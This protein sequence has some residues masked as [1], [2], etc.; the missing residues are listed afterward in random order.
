[1]P[2]WTASLDNTRKKRSNGGL[3]Y[4]SVVSHLLNLEA[5]TA[6]EA[7]TAAVKARMVKALVVGTVGSEEEA[8]AAAVVAA[9][10]G[11]VVAVAVA[12]WEVA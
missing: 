8:T 9:A 10:L 4:G 11:E 7:G 3:N 1:M 12:V 5:G 2:L 6:G